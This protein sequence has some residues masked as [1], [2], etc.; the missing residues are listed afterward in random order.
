[1]GKKIVQIV[2]LLSITLI[3]SFPSCDP[4]DKKADIP[5]YIKVDTVK[6]QF[7]VSLEGTDQQKITDVWFNLDGNRV[8]TF[9]IPTTFPVIALGER[10]IKIYPGFI[11]NGIYDLR[12]IHPFL[13]PYE[14]TVDFQP[15]EVTELEPVFEYKP[16]TKVWLENFEDPGLKFH[17]SDS[18]NY[19]NQIIDPDDSNNHL[20][21]V[22]LPDS[23]GYFDFYTERAMILSYNPVYMEFDYK[24]TVPFSIGIRALQNDGKY[25][26][27][28]PFTQIKPKDEWNKLYVNLSEQFVNASGGTAFDVYFIF[29]PVEGEVSEVYFD[30]FKILSFD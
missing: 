23:A 3:I 10:A 19:L 6:F 18:V 29:S 8:G 16:E 4:S 9:E 5:A 21:H 24:S 7:D 17:T 30:N 27:A 13:S 2:F 22:L 20:G 28:N 25:D 26:Y 11:K 15:G 12:E 14:T 1:M